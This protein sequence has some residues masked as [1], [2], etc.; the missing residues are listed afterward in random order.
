MKSHRSR[1]ALLAMMVL[2]SAGCVD[3]ASPELRLVRIEL[4]HYGRSV[5][6]KDRISLTAIAYDDRNRII[7]APQLSWTSDDPSIA[8]VDEIGR[9]T[10]HAL[11]SATVRATA[12][13]GQ[14]ASIEIAVR[15]AALRITLQAGA[16]TIIAG[17]KLVLR[18]DL[19]DINGGP[20][21]SDA[22]IRWTTGD[23]GIVS[24]RPGGVTPGWQAEV[25]ARSAGLATITA[26]VGDEQGMYV[27]AVLSNRGPA[28]PPLQIA[29]FAFF[30]FG[31]M[32][33]F[34][35]YSP[36]MRVKVAEGRRVEILRVD[37]LVPIQPHRYPALCST[38]TLSSGQHEILGPA[39][40]SFDLFE[41][42]RFMTPPP[43]DGL[44][45]LRYRADDGTVSELATRSQVVVKGESPYAYATGHK[46]M[47]CTT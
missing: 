2:L 28:N 8:T 41:S 3:T 40:Y 31:N 29:E 14:Q 36:A 10:G 23:T 16:P 35:V 42:F 1:V 38:E 21:P 7:P 12:A 44:V 47:A 18:A 24:V 9:V 25:E 43:I 5:A 11:G 13:T 27:L 4:L 20:I 46:W 45:L 22:P 6:V 32:S 33:D 39:S 17:E 30:E 37:V 19:V 15:A 34:L 26:R